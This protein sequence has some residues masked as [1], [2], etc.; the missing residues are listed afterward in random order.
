[1]PDPTGAPPEEGAR[2]MS[3]QQA[4]DDLSR[5]SRD[6]VR[7]GTGPS[8]GRRNTPKPYG[9]KGPGGMS[10]SQGYNK[11]GQ[12]KPGGPGSQQSG[13]RR[14]GSPQRRGPGG[15]YAGAGRYAQNLPAGGGTPPGGQSQVA[16]QR[17]SS[18]YG[19]RTSGAQQDQDGAAQDEGAGVGAEADEQQGGPSIAAFG[20]GNAARPA[21][22]TQASHRSATSSV[23]SSYRSSYSNQ[24][25]AQGGRGAPGS[26][27]ADRGGVGDRSP[28]NTRRGMNNANT[29][30]PSTRRRRPGQVEPGE[31][32]PPQGSPEPSQAPPPGTKSEGTVRFADGSLYTGE[33]ID[34][35]RHGKGTYRSAVGT[36]FEGSWAN[37]KRNGQ[38]IE[39]Y[40]I[41]NVYEGNWLDDQKHGYGVVS[42]LSSPRRA[43]ACVGEEDIEDTGGS[44]RF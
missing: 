35:I 10:G 44:G 34:N 30:Q 14:N 42:R 19:Q 7:R 29:P 22:G 27:G 28:G 31:V 32:T 2:T 15:Q 25:P 41:G 6:G 5:S 17:G 16:S 33:L 38:G 4:D 13:G 37:G 26:Y 24:K 39:K 1:M 36:F 8:P 21:P 20:W 43:R 18:G 12:R 3:E 40:P 11:T 23:G 9:S